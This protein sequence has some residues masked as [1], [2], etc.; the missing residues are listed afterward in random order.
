MKVESL[1]VYPVKGLRGIALQ[2]A[3]VETRGLSHDRRWMVTDEAG[4]FL[5][6]RECAALATIGAETSPDGSLSLSHG[7]NTITARATG[8]RLPVT[9]WKSA[10]EAFPAD[11]A[12]NAWISAVIG[13][14]ARLVFQGNVARATPPDYSLPGD[15]VSFA[16]GFPL[17]VANAAS[18]D[19]LNGRMEKP[20]PMNR[21]R[22]N[23]VIGGAEAW[24]EDTWRKLRIGDVVLDIVKPCARCI[25][26]TT[27]QHTGAREGNEPLA[28]LKTFRLLKK[29]GV[30]GVIFGQ[31]AIP[32]QTGVIRAGMEAE[33]LETAPAPAF[34]K[35][36]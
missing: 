11:D 32:R 18:L 25:V 12:A 36:G 30:T 14:A 6:Q 16:D 7:G 19:D 21:F 15:E 9:V 8:Q 31:N 2:E 29:P 35:M 33:V 5:T 20:L 27:D 34:E 3:A 22:P 1:H 4:K 26:T 13:R 28:T 10:V 17:L 23:I 24:A